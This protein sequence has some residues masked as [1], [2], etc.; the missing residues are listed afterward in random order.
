[1]RNAIFP[2]QQ[3]IWWRYVGASDPLINSKAL[4]NVRLPSSS[5]YFDIASPVEINGRITYTL[6]IRPFL[7]EF[8]INCLELSMENLEEL[9]DDIQKI[10]SAVKAFGRSSLISSINPAKLTLVIYIGTSKVV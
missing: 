10:G 3:G 2:V 9:F 1:M 7:A 5:P 6:E 8:R 4:K